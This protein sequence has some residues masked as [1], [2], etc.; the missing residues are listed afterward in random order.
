MIFA[1]GQLLNTREF[2]V[3]FAEDFRSSGDRLENLIQLMY[4]MRAETPATQL[5]VNGFRFLNSR[6]PG[7]LGRPSYGGGGAAGGGSRPRREPSSPG[8]GR[9][10][11]DHLLGAAGDALD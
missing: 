10:A 5:V 9:I 1:R 7:G 3:P 8:A 6:A 2:A 4:L 11:E